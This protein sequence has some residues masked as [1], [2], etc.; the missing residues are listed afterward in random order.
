[1]TTSAP[2]KK[3]VLSAATPS[4]LLTLGNYLGAIRNWV[5]MAEENDC[6]F[7]MADQ[8]AITVRQDPKELRERTYV[9]LANYIAAG[10]DP[11]KVVLFVQSHVA[12]H[13]QLTW[14]LMCH[15]Y[16]GELSRMTQFKDKSGQ[17]GGS[18]GQ[19]IPAGLFTYPVLMAADILL[20]QAHLVPVGEDQKQHIE[21]T[22]DLAIRMNNLYGA[23]LFTV[24]DPMIPK[25]GA[26]IMSLQNPTAKMSKSDADVNATIYLTDG[27]E[28]IRRKLKR[29][30]TD[31]GSEVTWSDEKPGVKNLLSIQSAITGKTA[32]ELVAS[33][34][35]KMYGHLKVDT[36]EIVV[37]A[38]SPI[39]RRS[40]ELLAD[41]AE[42]DR[43]LKR[44][45]EKARERAVKTLRSV[46]DAVG[47]ITVT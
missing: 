25:V 27:D 20:Y 21:L 43:L 10:L 40:E 28:V 16:M 14:L 6:L 23:K 15:A 3:T 22:R 32:D 7:M 18:E 8:H 12:E 37:S 44:G 45:A 19:N 36:A 9:A 24:P 31:S 29:A 4:N 33:Y 35:G 11:E 47:F 2:T 30:V 42:L 1:M 17:K 41:R 26:R 5:A 34:T 39:R 13:A 46:E 38:V